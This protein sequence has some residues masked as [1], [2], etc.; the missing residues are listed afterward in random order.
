MFIT[1]GKI[2]HRSTLTTCQTNP[3]IHLSSTKYVI[4]HQLEWH[5]FIPCLA[6]KPNKHL[7]YHACTTY[8]VCSSVL[9][10]AWKPLSLAALQ[11]E[12]CHGHKGH[13]TRFFF[14]WTKFPIRGSRGVAAVI[15]RTP[16]INRESPSPPLP[17]NAWFPLLSWSLR[18][19]NGCCAE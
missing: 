16:R 12:P 7:L 3:K 9:H 2:A 15:L 19:G 5:Y 18:P 17:A 6:P 14:H 11:D 10:E 4:L 8:S 13:T 1:K